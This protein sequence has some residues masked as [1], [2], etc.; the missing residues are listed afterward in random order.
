M[1]LVKAFILN[2]LLGLKLTVA[3]VCSFVMNL[4]SFLFGQVLL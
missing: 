3:V 2:H 4:A 1:F